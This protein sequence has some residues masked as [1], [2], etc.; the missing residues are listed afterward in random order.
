MNFTD[1]IRYAYW[2]KIK[3]NWRFGVISSWLSGFMSPIESFDN[4][5]AGLF[6]FTSC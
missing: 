3:R 2:D 6:K 1:E 5:S 4:D